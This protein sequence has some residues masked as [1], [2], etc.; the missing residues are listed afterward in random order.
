MIRVCQQ[1]YSQV[2]YHSSGAIQHIPKKCKYTEIVLVVGG[3]CRSQTAGRAGERLLGTSICA[4]LF[5]YVV[6]HV[7]SVPVCQRRPPSRPIARVLQ[8]EIV[9]TKALRTGLRSWRPVCHVCC[10]SAWDS[11]V[12]CVLFT[13]LY[14]TGES[15]RDSQSIIYGP[16]QY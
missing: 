6:M 3:G 4:Y 14:R 11:C 15:E 10:S 8:S 2:S 1:S 12:N 9:V 5:A 7:L 13:R 16:P